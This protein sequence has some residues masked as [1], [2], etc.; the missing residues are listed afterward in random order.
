MTVR[1][2]TRPSGYGY[3]H[4][5][6]VRNGCLVTV[7]CKVGTNRNPKP[8]FGLVVPP[9]ME[10]GVVTGTHARK[11]HFKPWIECTRRAEASACRG[12]DPGRRTNAAGDI[13]GTEVAGSM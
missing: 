5:V 6:Y 12:K 7:D 10:K 1:S 3:D 9:G 4:I 13:R 2:T 8:E 11:R